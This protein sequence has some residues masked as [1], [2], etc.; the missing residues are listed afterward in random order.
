[1]PGDGLPFEEAH[2]IVSA[3]ATTLQSVHSDGVVHRDIKADNIMVRDSDGHPVLVDFGLAYE[4]TLIEG[5]TEIGENVGNKSLRLP[6]HPTGGRD[7]RSDLTM[8]TGVF[9]FLL[10]GAEPRQLVDE[11][12]RRPHQRKKFQ[13]ALSRRMEIP[14]LPKLLVFFDRAFHPDINHR[15]QDAA[16][17]RAALQ[18]LMTPLTSYTAN[19]ESQ[20]E[21]LVALAEHP[22]L[23]AAQNTTRRV[24]RFMYEIEVTVNTLAGQHGLQIGPK[25]SAALDPDGAGGSSTVSLQ[26]PSV[27]PSYLTFWVRDLGGGETGI[28]LNGVDTPFWRGNPEIDNTD[29]RRLIGAELLASVNDR[30]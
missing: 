18:D 12:E 25:R 27:M 17:Y 24:E 15:W 5:V 6:E 30:N 26:F 10:T 11:Y 28:G 9:L 7:P 20:V 2:S 19:Y 1:V 23:Q 21:R 16:A 13:E 8:L 14:S 29:L 4:D 3:L 22:D